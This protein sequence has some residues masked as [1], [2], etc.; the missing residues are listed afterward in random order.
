MLK[1]IET[2]A[3]Y[4]FSQESIERKFVEDLLRYKLVENEGKTY[5]EIKEI[6]NDELDRL[7]D[8]GIVKIYH[9]LNSSPMFAIKFT[10]LS[11][12]E[13]HMVI[14]PHD[15]RYSNN[16]LFNTYDIDGYYEDKKIKEK[17]D[18]L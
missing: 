18:A 10:T 11:S 1:E 14:L 13:M 2:I 16:D 3:L 8:L 5:L 6:F 12:D 15:S 4:R 9:I 17:K 7:Y